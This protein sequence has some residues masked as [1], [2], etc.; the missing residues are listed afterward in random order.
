MRQSRCDE[1]RNERR[2]SRV[3]PGWPQRRRTRAA[4][5]GERLTTRPMTPALIVGTVHRLREPARRGCL[6]LAC[7]AVL[8]LPVGAGA[9]ST[10]DDATALA[11]PVTGH[12]VITDMG[13]AET[14]VVPTPV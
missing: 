12:I 5:N 4:G 8:G 7:A 2:D 14:H 10:P 9:Q 3:L 1:R 11:V 6:L 13:K